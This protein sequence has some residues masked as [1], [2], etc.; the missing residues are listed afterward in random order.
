MTLFA[1]LHVS[2]T[3]FFLSF[4]VWSLPPTHCTCSVFLMHLITVSDTHTHTHM[5]VCVCV[6]CA[7]HGLAAWLHVPGCHI[8]PAWYTGLVF[9]TIWVSFILIY[10]AV[11]FDDA[12]QSNTTLLLCQTTNRCIYWC[13]DL[14]LYC[15]Q[16]SLLHVSAICCGHIQI[17][18][19]V[20]YIVTDFDPFT[21]NCTFYTC[22]LLYRSTQYS[23]QNTS[24]KMATTGGRNM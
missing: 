16:C 13:V 2:K 4:L 7:R 23:S 14:L 15:N 3:S 8:L 21:W 5:C 9:K 18:V 17:I 6:W 22:K 10:P 12:L 11:L 20:F 24:L 1:V 19:S